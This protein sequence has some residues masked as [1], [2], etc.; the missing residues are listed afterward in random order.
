M[1]TVARALRCLLSGFC[2][3]AAK[4]DRS[5]LGGKGTCYIRKIPRQ[6][7]CDSTLPVEPLSTILS[8]SFRWTLRMY[9]C[10]FSPEEKGE[11]GRS[12]FCRQYG[13][14]REDEDWIPGPNAL[15]WRAARSRFRRACRADLDH[16][17]A[18]C[19]HCYQTGW[20]DP[21]SHEGRVFA[22]QHALRGAQG[23]ATRR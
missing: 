19:C 5:P 13:A 12:T 22:G 7:K 11:R 15:R 4:T 16:N 20:H 23:R 18:N 9:S 17:L 2:V 1:R 6:D 21:E 10:D 8:E 14:G 3:K